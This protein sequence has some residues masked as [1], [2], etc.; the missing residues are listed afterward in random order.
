VDDIPEDAEEIRLALVMNG[1]V[2]LAV[3]MG[4]VVHELDLLRR[5]SRGESEEGV[6]KTDLPVFRFW[7]RLTA[8]A[9]DPRR[10]RVDIIAGTSA[11]G[12]NGMLLATAIAR[13]AAL[14]GLR[15]VWQHSAALDRL[16]DEPSPNSM[17]SGEFFQ[18]KLKEAL[19][20]VPHGD[21]SYS[22]SEPVTLFVTATALDGRSRSFTDSFGNHFGV[23]DHRRLYR[24]ERYGEDDAL[25]Y[26]PEDGE[27]KIRKSRPR[28]DF[29]AGNTDVLVQAARATAGFPVAFPP[30]SE[31]PLLE[32]REL[33]RKVFDDPASCVMD[34]GILD[35]E[36]F[37]P[38]L[39]AITRRPL[40]RKVKRVL[41][42][43]VPSGGRLP[44]EKAED[45]ACEEISAATTGFS[46]LGLP[47]EVDFRSTTEELAARLRTNTRPTGEELFAR[48]HRARLGEEPGLLSGF[49]DL[50]RGVFPEYRFNRARGV[51][52]EVRELLAAADAVTP[53][54]FPPRVETA[55]IHE[56]L[57]RR[58]GFRWIPPDDPDCFTDWDRSWRWG[59]LP[60]ER[61][62]QTLSGHLQERADAEDRTRRPAA[63]ARLIE[64]AKAV[65]GEVR[66]VL[67]VNDAVA[68]RL[69]RSFPRSGRLSDR[70]AAQLL[71]EVFAEPDVPASVAEFVRT[72][73]DH[74][75]RAVA[76]VEGHWEGPWDVVTDCLVIEV[77]TQAFA[78]PSGIAEAPAPR[79]DLLRLA[80]DT[81]SR[82]FHDDRFGDLGERKLYGVRFQNFG[83]FVEPGWRHSDFVWGRLDTVHH[84]L[85]LFL[86]SDE[87]ARAAETEAHRL[88][89][90]AELGSD[91]VAW[92]REHL[93]VLKQG[94]NDLDL[95]PT[96]PR[97]Y[98]T[99]RT[100][101]AVNRAVLRVVDGVAVHLRP[102]LLR[103][104]L[105]RA[106]SHVLD[107][108]WRA[109]QGRS[110]RTAPRTALEAV[111]A[112]FIRAAVHLAVSALLLLVAGFLLGVLLG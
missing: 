43:V 111:R 38:V 67:A 11:G 27:W 69:Q 39:D 42:H 31:L 77:L 20:S 75:T 102:Q 95:L 25:V 86:D 34:G 100:R 10:V 82:L 108:F 70:E 41:V 78:P 85:P 109:A 13:D 21:A 55:E 1:G 57:A 89:L 9:P 81:M 84:L 105:R 17:F 24:F 37:G 23:R 5:A 12:L 28:N 112:V 76:E 52:L 88:I 107:E 103:A 54:V 90:N 40:D 87:E 63:R 79:F 53:L 68:A 60:A 19:Q 48:F 26:T 83:A 72:A 6:K 4:G 29:T 61:V 51:V 56:F 94:D 45:R 74:Y 8:E 3:W 46:A 71:D 22:G 14:P 30:V 44:E 96:V 2:S 64:G 73:N 93:T 15:E 110:P 99:L 66:K 101:D 33:P 92:M 50:A 7:R 16:L 104:W 91:G 47:R 49:F 97:T 35:N 98:E 65:N 59:L 62:L 106:A 80:P 36:P 18:E 58:P 32:Y